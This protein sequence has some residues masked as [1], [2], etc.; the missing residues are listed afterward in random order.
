MEKRKKKKKRRNNDRGLSFVCYLLSSSVC[1]LF[2]VDLPLFV[3]PFRRMV[4]SL[5]ALNKA[6]EIDPSHELT[7][8]RLRDTVTYLLAEYQKKSSTVPQDASQASFAKALAR[9]KQ[10]K[11][12][13][14]N[15]RRRA[16]KALA[17]AEFFFFFAAS[18]SR[19]L[20]FCVIL[21]ILL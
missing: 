20:S 6:A 12:L 1:H 8:D 14:V 5:R 2:A 9:M 18:A 13:Q 19:F 11:A 7:L 21:Y 15:R 4:E 10:D 16:K 17:I 3:P